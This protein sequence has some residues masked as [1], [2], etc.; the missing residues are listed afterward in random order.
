[1]EQFELRALIEDVRTEK[2]PRRSFIERMVGLGLTAPMASMMLM[3]SGVAQSQSAPVYKPARRGGGGALKTLW[4][5]APPLLH[6]HSA[7]G[8]KHQEAPLVFSAPL[9]VWNNDGIL[10]P[11]PPAEIPGV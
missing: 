6:P 1:M 8:T 11:T 10:V 5:Q 3:H 4:W 9:G 2:L 7:T